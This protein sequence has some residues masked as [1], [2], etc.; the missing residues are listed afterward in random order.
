ME[1]VNKTVRSG[2]VSMVALPS[3]YEK[4]LYDLQ[5]QARSL[6]RGAGIECTKRLA[7]VLELLSEIRS[8]QIKFDFAVEEKIKTSIYETKDWLQMK[9][10]R[11]K[12][13]DP[14]AFLYKW[15]S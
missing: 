9:T 13:F 8:F 1:I 4:I 7:H 2:L 3:D 11:G 6:S 5:T 14:L 10:N 12:R 15:R